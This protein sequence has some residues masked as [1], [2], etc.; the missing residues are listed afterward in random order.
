MCCLVLVIIAVTSVLFFV[1][2]RPPNDVTEWHSNFAAGLLCPNNLNAA[3][4]RLN[5]C[6]DETRELGLQRII[7][8]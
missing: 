6:W 5:C 8:C 7:Y 2:R 3:R 1:A 4:K